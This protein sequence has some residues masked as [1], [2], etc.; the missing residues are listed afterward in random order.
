[1]T[2]RGCV[3]GRR[4]R[5]GVAMAGSPWRMCSRGTQRTWIGPDRLPSCPGR[6]P[7]ASTWPRG[8]HSERRRP[9]CPVRASPAGPV[10]R[11]HASGRAC[12]AHSLGQGGLRSALPPAL[13]AAP[14]VA[15]R[16]LDECPSCN[17]M[18][19]N[20]QLEKNLR[21]CPRCGHHFRLRVDAR[22]APRCSTPTPSR[23]ATRAS[24]RSTRSASWTP[25]PTPTRSASSAP[26]PG[27]RDAAVWGIGRIGG[28]P[29]LDLRHGLR[30]HGRLD[31]LGR[32]R[33]GHA[34]GRG[35][36]RRA[37]A[38]HRGQRVGRGADAGGHAG[39]DAARQDVRRAR[40]PGA[41]PACPT[42]AS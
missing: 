2:S 39:P 37:A 40:A 17:E 11:M 13:P 31:G 20:K 42:S 35:C 33:E 19:Y 24:N 4:S 7:G 18:L 22:L 9:F 5:P 38:P 23:S 3:R 16:P 30:L 26:R 27:I 41:M 6:I 12:P 14:R 34:R 10:R 8:R 15:R 32:R 36:P 1:M 28:Q 29:V 25:R 21:V